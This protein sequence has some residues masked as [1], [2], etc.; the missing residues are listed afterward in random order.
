ME[1]A[2]PGALV[3]GYEKHI[4]GLVMPDPDDRHVLA[5]AIEAGAE[6]IITFN[7][8]DFPIHLLA[9]FGV[10]AHHPDRFLLDLLERAPTGVLTAIRA[11]RSAFKKPPLSTEEYL[12]KLEKA[13]LAE[14]AEYLRRVAPS[15]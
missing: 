3:E 12:H 8:R 14:T 9:P 4:E 11:Q 6:A 2:V 7:L 13:Q 1:A 5:A 15:L 10:A